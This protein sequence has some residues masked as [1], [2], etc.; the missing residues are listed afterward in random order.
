V[1]A[2]ERF[3]LESVAAGTAGNRSRLIVDGKPVRT[4]VHGDAISV[5]L[6]C[7]EHFLVATHFDCFEVVEYWF[8]LLRD[9]GTVADLASTPAYFGFLQ[10]LSIDGPMRISFGFF[11]TNDRWT[12]SVSETGYWSYSL[13][14]MARRLNRFLLSKRYISMERR[15]GATLAGPVEQGKQ[16]E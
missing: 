2:T 15:K 10:E 12:L 13:G 7:G 4:F 11:G 5:Q 1:I 14:A 8:Y 16:R 3:A 9:N 6:A